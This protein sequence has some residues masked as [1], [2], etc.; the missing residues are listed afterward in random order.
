M[1][2]K[3]RIIIAIGGF[4]TLSLLILGIVQYETLKSALV[5]E[6]DET[7]ALRASNIS[8]EIRHAMEKGEPVP[9]FDRLDVNPD[10]LEDFP[11]SE[12]FIQINDD[13]GRVLTASDNL[14]NTRLPMIRTDRDKDVRSIEWKAGH[15]IRVMTLLLNLNGTQKVRIILAESLFLL[16]ASLRKTI[17]I[18]IFTSLFTLFLVVLFSYTILA[19]ALAP[20]ERTVHTAYS[21]IETNDFSRRVILPR[22]LDEAGQTAHVFNVLIDRVEHLLESQRQLLAC[23][24]HELRNPLTVI[25]T[26]LDMLKMDIDSRNREE[27]SR[28]AE[29]EVER[30]SRLIEDLLLLSSLDDNPFFNL[31]PV[32]LSLLAGEIITSMKPFAEDRKID[33]TLHADPIVTGDRDRI[34]QVVCNLV[35]NSIRYTL[36][37]GRISIIVGKNDDRAYLVVEDN[38]IGI[39]A[40]HLPHIFKRFYRVDKARSRKLG[41]TGLG[42]TIAKTF[43]EALGGTID[44][45]ST[46]NQGSI[47][48]L[49]LPLEPPAITQKNG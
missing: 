23:T 36:P 42:L 18:T 15:H 49:Q 46:V 24:S 20:L 9:A 33:L 43:V 44:V 21:I 41:G 10:S 19:W 38:G 45:K 31:E 35:E 28:E 40:E 6:V 17:R 37:D 47:F 1:S 48:T 22:S 30:M 27:V 39:P 12:I 13:N 26:D 25:R 5:S 16:E 32:S 7:L 2:L 3:L 34:R 14:R 29:K 4:L 8:E 11:Y